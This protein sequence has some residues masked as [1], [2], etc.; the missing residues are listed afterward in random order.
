MYPSSTHYDTL[1]FNTIENP[2]ITG[3]SPNNTLALKK[4]E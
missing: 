4:Y 2:Y 3:G 1:K